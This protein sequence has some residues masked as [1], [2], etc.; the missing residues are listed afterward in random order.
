MGLILIADNSALERQRLKQ[1]IES[2]GHIVVLANNNKYCLELIEVHRLNAALL[3]PFLSGTKKL[4]L[5][6]LPAL[7]RRK[8]PVIVLAKQKKEQ[9]YERCLRYEVVVAIL[10]EFPSDLEIKQNIAIALNNI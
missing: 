5:R 6:L 9:I 1:I 10:G 3:D 2:E 7:Q 8:I 4:E